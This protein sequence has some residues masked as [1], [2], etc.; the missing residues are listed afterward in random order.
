MSEVKTVKE[1]KE[2]IKDVP[3]D[4][5][6]VCTVYVESNYVSTIEVNSELRVVELSV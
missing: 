1:L 2:L 6:L 5:K 4:Y 3:D